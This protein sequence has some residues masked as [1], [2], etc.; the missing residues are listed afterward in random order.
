MS[1]PA[2]GF[3]CPPILVFCSHFVR[4]GRG[5]GKLRSSLCFALTAQLR[6]AKRV[7]A[8]NLKPVFA[9]NFLKNLVPPHSN[10][11]NSEKISTSMISRKIFLPEPWRNC[12]QFWGQRYLY[13]ST[14]FTFQLTRKRTEK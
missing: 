6:G 4:F 12:C 5:L 13:L 3:C 14:T 8:K 7:L 2:S 1:R 9:G 11:A 10:S